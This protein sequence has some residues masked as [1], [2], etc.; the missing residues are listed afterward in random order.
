MSPASSTD[1]IVSATSRAILFAASLLPASDMAFSQSRQ[2]G[3]I[4]RF[5]LNGTSV[6]ATLDDNATTRDFLARLPLTLK[7]EDYAATEKIA[8]LPSKLSIEGAPSAIDPKA[9]DLTYC[10]HWGNL[11]LFHKDF[12]R[13]SRP[14]EAR[15]C[16]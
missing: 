9:G 6:V 4:I 2:T 12:R 8:Y 10:A 3:M 14:R 13:S 1:R 15:A 7:L 16:R 11:A 5:T